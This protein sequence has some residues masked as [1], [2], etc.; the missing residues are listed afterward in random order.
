MSVADQNLKL[1]SQAFSWRK[2]VPCV[3]VFAAAFLFFGLLWPAMSPGVRASIA[4]DFC[5]PQTASELS[6]Q[7]LGLLKTVIAKQASDQLTGKEFDSLIQQTQSTGNVA[8][9]SIEYYDRETIAKNIALGFAMNSG[10]GRLQID[11]VCQGNPDQIRFL[12]LLGQRLANSIEAVA[13]NPESQII[14]G[15]QPKNEKFER[16]I[17]LGQSN[18]I[19]PQPNSAR[20]RSPD[21]PQ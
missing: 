21:N 20:I 14:A 19:G 13:L 2:I 16:A 7:D 4:V 10:N 11:Y 3:I 15:N 1:T 5:L 9:P 12:Q 18:P 8:S 17:W 6:E